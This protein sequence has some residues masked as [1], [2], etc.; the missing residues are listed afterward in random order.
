MRV[1]VPWVYVLAYLVG[2]GLEY[3]APSH[4]SVMGMRGISLGGTVLLTV[5]VVIAGSG[6]LIFLRTRTTTIPGEVSSRLVTWGPYR[7]SRNPMYVGLLIAYLGEAA[8]LRQAWPLLLLPFVFAY[9]NWMVVP[10]EEARLK[11][12]FGMEYERYKA[13]VRRW[14]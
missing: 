1:P 4:M 12:V 10:V 8:F 13:K 14:I 9:I 11:E 2:A 7:F 6:W 5:G 3:L